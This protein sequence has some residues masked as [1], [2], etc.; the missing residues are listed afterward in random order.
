MEIIKNLLKNT[1]MDLNN[2]LPAPSLPLNIFLKIFNKHSKLSIK[3]NHHV[4][5]YVR[6]AYKWSHVNVFGNPFDHEFIYHYD[7]PGMYVQVMLEKFPINERKLDRDDFDLKKPGF[8]AIEYG[9]CMDVPVLL[10]RRLNDKRLMFT[11]G[12]NWKRLLVWVN[13]IVFVFR[14]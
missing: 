6:K 12:G 1:N 4:S 14:R 11:D 13:S 3:H 10:P 2:I 7:V 9:S 8:Y 5:N